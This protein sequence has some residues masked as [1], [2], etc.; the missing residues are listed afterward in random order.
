MD[1]QQRL[2]S[3]LELERM[4]ISVSVCGKDREDRFL[5]ANE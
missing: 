5:A 3:T 2:S 1:A 4:Q